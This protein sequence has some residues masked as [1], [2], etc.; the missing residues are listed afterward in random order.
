M[1]A[2]SRPCRSTRPRASR[3][4]RSA[5]AS[6]AGW[7]STATPTRRPGAGRSRA[8]RSADSTAPWS[9][10]STSAIATHESPARPARDAAGT[11]GP[12]CTT[13]PTQVV[14]ARSAYST[15]RR[16]ECFHRPA[17]H[18][19]V[20]PSTAR[21]QWWRG[22]GCASGAASANSRWVC[23]LTRP[24]SSTPSTCCS[25]SASRRNTV[26]SPTA[27]IVASETSTPPSSSGGPVIGRTTLAENRTVDTARRVVRARAWRRCGT[28]LRR[29][30][31][32]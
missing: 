22:P 31:C 7:A 27:T 10:T 25:R 16:A 18:P 3:R 23:A 17:S 30:V 5:R 11:P 6:T 20:I 1:A 14:P 15:P 29:T 21:C 32:E 12:R 8:G 4:R 24:G 19:A 13:S 28:A 26:A 9:R 2:S